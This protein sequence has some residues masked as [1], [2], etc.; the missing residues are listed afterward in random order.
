MPELFSKIAKA[1]ESRG[2]RYYKRQTAISR[3]ET[4][5]SPST[6]HSQSQWKIL[7]QRK[8]QIY[9]KNQFSTNLEGI[10][11]DNLQLNWKW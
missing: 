11:H 7:P 6:S 1:Y 5:I 4:I 10:N 3:K 8:V 9:N 2:A